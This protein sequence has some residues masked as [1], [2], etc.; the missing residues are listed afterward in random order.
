MGKKVIKKI[1]H[2]FG[3]FKTTMPSFF[4]IGAQ[5][6]GTSY[7]FNFL[8]QQATISAPYKKELDYFS[9]DLNYSEGKDWYSKHFIFRNTCKTTFEACPNYL[10]YLD[11]HQRMYDFN[12]NIKLIIQLRNPTERA[13]SAWNMHYEMWKNRKEE[14]IQNYYH[15][16][17][18]EQK[19]QGINFINQINFPSF[20][21][22]ISQEIKSINNH[23]F[24]TTEPGFIS[25]GLYYQQIKHLLSIFKREQILIIGNNTLKNRN[26]LTQQLE[27]FLNIPIKDLELEK[28]MWFKGNYSNKIDEESLF[29]LNNFFEEKNEQLFNL[30]Q[31]EFSW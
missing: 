8:N 2:S 4:I 20:K 28:E 3:L 25:R 10:Y 21:E 31:E 26:S 14:V 30:I 24:V 13:F 15:I 1:A 29:I 27:Q 12:P 6:C 11:S 18:Q 19:K 22:A 5:K 7:L 16:L 9:S 17:N 23:S